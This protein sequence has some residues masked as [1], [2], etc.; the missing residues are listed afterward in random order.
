[1]FSEK[2]GMI[3]ALPP[4]AD[5]FNTNPASDVISLRNAHSVSFL[6]WHQGGTTGT[7]KITVQSCDNVAPSNTTAIPFRYRKMTTGDSDA[8]GPVVSTSAATGFTTVATENTIYEVEVLAC[9]LPADRP[10]VR[11]KIDEVENDPVNAV[12]LALL[13]GVRHQGLNQPTAIA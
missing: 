10:F 13:D 7:G 9:E 4:A 5:R 12:V 8:V 11:L 6:I 1:M 2:H 3:K